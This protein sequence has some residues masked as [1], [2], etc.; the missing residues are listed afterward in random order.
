MNHILPISTDDR[1]LELEYQIRRFESFI[2]SVSTHNRVDDEEFLFAKY[3]DQIRERRSILNLLTKEFP[4]HFDTN[5]KRNIY[6]STI[7]MPFIPAS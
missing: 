7:T 2:K 5:P 4:R 3:N 1:L 6:D